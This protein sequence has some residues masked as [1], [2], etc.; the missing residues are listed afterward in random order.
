VQESLPLLTDSALLRLY[1]QGDQRAFEQLVE[2]Y[3]APLFCFLL[4]ILRDPD[5]TEDGGQ[6][7]VEA[8]ADEQPDR[9]HE[10]HR[11]GETDQVGQRAGGEDGAPIRREGAEAVGDPLGEI[12]GDAHRRE[13]DVASLRSWLF[14]VARNRAIDLL[15]RHAREKARLTS[16]AAMTTDAENAPNV[17]WMQDP[18]PGP[19]VL[20]EQRAMYD[21]LLQVL[22]TFPYHSQQIMYLRLWHQLSYVSIGQRLGMSTATVKTYFHRSRLRLSKALTD[23]VATGVLPE[24][25]KRTPQHPVCS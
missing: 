11:V 3:Q 21:A 5:T 7:V 16:L 22:A 8:E 10:P 15:R 13:S 19:E 18:R 1:H 23:W 17:L 14:H 4:G 6:G 12:L 9:D 2:R 20:V 25:R 24:R